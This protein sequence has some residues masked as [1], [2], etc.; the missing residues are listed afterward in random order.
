MSSRSLAAARARRAGD[1]APP[2]SGNRPGTS[3]GSQAAFSQQQH[4]PP[5]S[6]NN[7]RVARPIQQPP[8]QQQQQQQQQHQY[9]QQHYQQQ[10]EEQSQVNRRQVTKIR[11][12]DAISLITLRLG[13][14]EQWIAESETDESSGQQGASYIPDNNKIIDS[15]VLTTIINRLDSLEKNSLN[16]TASGS[17][18]SSEEIG[19]LKENVS[20]LTE[21]FT[22]MGDEV[23]KHR[24]ELAKQTEQVFRFNREL[25]ETKDILK[26]F[27]VKYDMFTQEMTT[28]LTDYEDALS[29][30]EKRLP[31]SEEVA[32]EDASE[33]AAEDD[34]EPEDTRLTDNDDSIENNIMSV[35][36]KSIIKHELANV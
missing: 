7:V 22:N 5:Q 3:I 17:N 31:S 27:M 19:E 23:A 6:T 28:N 9:Q 26:S 18:V 35:D 21:Q 34:D 1:L 25:T 10:Y 20:K 32:P 12:V 8:Q 29:D 33:Q 2:V 4:M 11:I 30:L 15:S 13:R 36:L 24:I 14:V 16:A